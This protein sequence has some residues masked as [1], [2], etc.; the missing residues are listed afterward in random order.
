VAPTPAPDTLPDDERELYERTRRCKAS[1]VLGLPVLVS[2]LSDALPGQPLQRLFGGALPWLELALTA[3]VLVSGAPLYRRAHRAFAAWRLDRFS[4]LALG[5]GAAV[6]LS[7]AGT[8]A[9]AALPALLRARAGFAPV[10]FESAVALVVLALLGEVLELRAHG[11]TSGALREWLGLAPPR[12]H[13]LR[14]GALE[15]EVP[16]AELQ[17][18]DRL[19]VRAGERVP[20]DG[21]VVEG[22]SAIDESMVTGEPFAVEKTPGARVTAGTL[23]GSGALVVRAERVGGATLLAQIGRLLAE[24]PASGAPMQARADALAAALVPVAVL[25]AIVTG[26]VASAFGPAPRVTFA[27]AQVLLV[28]LCACPAALAV[29]TPLALLVGTARGAHAGVLIRN[30]AALEQ[31]ARVDTLVIDK[32]GTLT[33]GRPKLSNLSAAPGFDEARMLAL[34]ASLE[35]HGSHPLGQG[36]VA[37]GRAR[38]L[39]ISEATKVRRIPGQGIIGEVAGHTIALGSPRLC[40]TLGAHPG[41]Y[42]QRA[43]TWRKD[44]QSVVF[45]ILDGKFAGLLGLSDPMRASSAEAVR[46]LRA[47][48]LRLVLLSGD[49]RATAE[50]V[51]GRVGIDEVIADVL[52]EEKVAAVERLRATGRRVAMAGDGACDGAL[53]A[54]DVGVALGTGAGTELP[55]AGVTLVKGDLRGVARARRVCR[56][57][58]R[59]AQLSLFFACVFH[60]LALPIAAGLLLS[61]CG[62]LFTPRVAFAIILLGAAGVAASTLWLRRTSL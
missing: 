61:P 58:L 10:Y 59:S 15:E 12:A 24:A 11:A 40:A 28:L 62:W 54:A 19:R 1:L 46:L 33:E 60:L 2:G 45:V 27:L 39:P 31:L 56:A 18:G 9:P 30:A 20:A 26:F 14:V 32:T 6:V 8:F 21:V 36:I 23:N 38:G 37:G 35:K 43:A 34:A 22:T 3:A 55:A 50:S 57:T 13:R 48:K 44:G 16:L 41:P 17:V 25:L 7:L 29:A 52:P 49:A 42:A 4:L 5:V 47:Q 51:A 53:A